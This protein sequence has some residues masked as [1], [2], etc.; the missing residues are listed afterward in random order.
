MNKMY[1]MY[2]MY[3]ALATASI[4]ALAAIPI[5]ASAQNVP[6]PTKHDGQGFNVNQVKAIPAT[7]GKITNI[8]NDDSGKTI[9]VTGRGLVLTD[10]SEIILSITKDT[11][12]ID[13]RGKRVSLQSIIDENKVS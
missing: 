5:P 12:I 13:A 7:V 2:K 3:K 6:P 11:K 8:V 1:K 10:Q 9:T 4:I